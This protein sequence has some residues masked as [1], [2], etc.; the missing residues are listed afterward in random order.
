MPKKSSV[1]LIP[2]GGL[3][4]VGKNLILLEKDNQI[5]IID[6][7]VNF[8][9]DEM[10]G[11]DYII[12]DFTYIKNNKKKVKAVIVTHGHEDH[13]GALPFLYKSINVPIYATKLTLGLIKI[14]LNGLENFKNIEFNKIDPGSPINIGPFNIDF[15]RVNHSI[16]DGVGLIINTDIGTILHT[17]DFK[18]DQSPI[19]GKVT[20][21]SKIVSAGQKGVL[22]MLCDS[23]NAEEE[24]YTLPERD[25][26]KNLKEKFLKADKRIIVATFASHI[27]RI[28]QILDVSKELQK[29]VAISGKSILKSIRISSELGYLKIP[30]NTIIPITKID[31]FPLKKIVILSTG[32][33]GEPLSALNKMA[34]NDHKR[35]KIM[36][37][38]M[39]VISASPIPG[40]EKA[41]SNTINM[42]IE[43]GADV[44]YES[45]AG[46][47]V[48][49][50]AA[51]EEI[52]MMLSLVKPKY[53][54]PIH[55]ENKHKT[56]NAKIANSMG[57]DDKHI[58]LVGNG[59]I[60]KMNTNMCRVSKSLN[61]KTI[62]ID[63]IGTG[64][65]GDMVL[66]DRK[67]LS[68]D[69]IIIAVVGIDEKNK[70]IVY[71]PDFIFKGVIY[72][73]DFERKINKCKEVVRKEIKRCFNE[74]IT[75]LNILEKQVNDKLRKY[76]YKKIKIRSI[77][78]TKIINT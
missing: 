28:Q 26:G 37:D 44:F 22:A 24:G 66:K 46:V 75:T 43:Q 31:D 1:K 58:L 63:G 55:G 33:Q 30:D 18:I 71:E 76:I 19:D 29:K 9:D 34:L 41:I 54:I 42:L 5:I 36:N 21:F 78:T 48:S 68:R 7:G 39:V 73:E 35:V 27:H 4:E 11:I 64:N 3:N 8:P 6:C 77:V 15:F 49:G 57:I 53:F 10:M 62:Y 51:K 45:I 13:I 47:H 72:I 14:K 38:D 12:P 2:L 59:S 20:Q 70:K 60:I 69:G 65:L 61:L 23:T 50:H 17:G 40:N 67:L 32:S 16:P 25:V 52:K 56:Q 74:D